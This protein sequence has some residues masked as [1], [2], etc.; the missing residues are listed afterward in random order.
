MKRRGIEIVVGLFVLAGMACLIYISLSLGQVGWF[1][2]KEYDVYAKFDN[3]EGLLF[4]ATVEIAGVQVGRV[5]GIQLIED[6]AQ[7]TLAIKAGIE[8]DNEVI[9][10]IRTKGVIGEK[11][12]RL[13]PGGGEKT[14]QNGDTITET[15]SGVDIMDLVSQFVHGDV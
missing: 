5:R 4:G 2:S 11:F 12:L 10:S 3:I 7:V 9:C 1:G 6:E 15:V 14:L 13:E 8:I